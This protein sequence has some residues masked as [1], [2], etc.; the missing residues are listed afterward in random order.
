M[1]PG[2]EQSVEHFLLFDSVADLHG[3][4]ELVG[5]ILGEFG[6]G[7]RGPVDA[8]A[9][10]APAEQN[11][12]VAGPGGLADAVSR[13]QPD[14]AAEHQR[15]GEVPLVEVH[16]PVDRG[17]PHAVAVV[18]DAGDDAFENARGMQHPARQALAGVI[19]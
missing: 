14:A 3:V 9:T 2:L 5:V 15:V 4:G 13:D 19:R 7:K 8:V 17:N 6:G 16:R 18:A 1:I 12:S 10:G 11:D